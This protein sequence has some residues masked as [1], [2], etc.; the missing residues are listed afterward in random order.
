MM[1]TGTVSPHVRGLAVVCGCGPVFVPF[2]CAARSKDACDYCKS[3][4]ARQF[5][6]KFFERVEISGTSLTESV[7]W[8]LGTSIEYVREYDWD[9]GRWVDNINEVTSLW[10]RFN[11][12]MKMEARRNGVAW[13]PLVYVVEAGSQGNRLHIHLLVMTRI[14]HGMVLRHW[15]DLTGE[16]SN[17]N[18]VRAKVGYLAKY[19]G[20]GLLRYSFLGVL[21]KA[22]PV[23]RSKCCNECGSK[24]QLLASSIYHEELDRLINEL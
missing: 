14:S 13:D 10:Q 7:M 4:R 24:Y 3:S 18:F 17:V 12:R 1:N 19:A 2:R 23:P 22:K 11:S 21:Y 6:S 15:R 5:L 16:S 8:T 9:S 20:K